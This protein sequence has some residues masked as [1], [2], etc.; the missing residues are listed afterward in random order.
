[1]TF[2]RAFGKL[3]PFLSSSNIKDFVS[4]FS[5]VVDNFFSSSILLH[6]LPK[7]RVSTQPK[8]LAILTAAFAKNSAEDI[9]QITGSYIT[10]S[11]PDSKAILVLSSFDIIAKS[12]R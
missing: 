10:K 1:M 4:F 11:I 5:R 12:P 6:S 2:S 3:T 9:A 8:L 7:L